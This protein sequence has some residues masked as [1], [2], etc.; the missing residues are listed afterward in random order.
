MKC[1]PYRDLVPI[2]RFAHWIEG[3]SAQPIYAPP[4]YSSNDFG[5][6]PTR[7]EPPLSIIL[8]LRAWR[9]LAAYNLLSIQIDRRYYVKGVF[10]RVNS[11]TLLARRP[12][13]GHSRWYSDSLSIREQLFSRTSHFKV[14]LEIAMPL[15]YAERGFR[16]LATFVLLK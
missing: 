7:R 14:I 10:G 8:D 16:R 9:P 12:R 15:N 5:K 1:F 2:C 3:L 4:L 6:S 11:S 13:Q